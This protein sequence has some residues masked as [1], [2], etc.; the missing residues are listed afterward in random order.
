MGHDD[1]VIARAGGDRAEPCHGVEAG[2]L[3]RDEIDRDRLAPRA[4]IE[5]VQPGPTRVQLV[6]AARLE[7]QRRAR[8]SMHDFQFR[9]VGSA[10]DAG[11]DRR[12]V[13]D[14]QAV[15]RIAAF[16]LVHALDGRARSDFD[17]VS[18]I[19]EGFVQFEI[20]DR[21]L[22][23]GQGRSPGG[24]ILQG[25]FQQIVAADDRVAASA[26]VH[27]DAMVQTPTVLATGTRELGHARNVERVRRVLPV[28]IAGGVEQDIS[29]SG[30]D[31]GARLQCSARLCRQVK[32]RG[33]CRLE[34]L[35]PSDRDMRAMGCVAVKRDLVVI[36]GDFPLR[37][38]FWIRHVS[39][40]R[41]IHDH[42]SRGLELE[43][44][45]P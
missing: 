14:D 12:S 45:D 10:A 37:V 11:R 40:P 27:A 30:V 2:G 36:P 28:R 22:R 7:N 42:V 18:G 20:G 25:P 26:K 31:V 13:V 32:M 4:V 1:L 35:G 21:Q 6:H 34:R 5:P 39:R 24:A 41:A 33:H 29:R 9:F 44:L 16:D 38:G 43:C 17:P 19:F 23:L 3:T 15:R 8:H